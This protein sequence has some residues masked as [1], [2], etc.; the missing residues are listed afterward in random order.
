MKSLKIGI[1]H[2]DINGISYEL[3]LKLF[4]EQEILELCTPVIFGCQ[5]VAD[6]TVKALSLEKLPFYLCENASAAIEGRINLVDVC[7]DEVPA[8]SY[9][10]QTEE[11]LKAEAQSLTAALEAYR[12]RHID[13][14]VTLPGHLS[15]ADGSHSLTNFISRAMGMSEARI[16]DWTINGKIRSLELHAPDASTELGEGLMAESL[17]Q[18][19]QAVHHSMRQDFLLLR[20]RI[21]VVTGVQKLRGILTELHESGITAFGPFE[22]QTF[23]D[24]QWQSHYDACLFLNE[25]DALSHVMDQEEAEN[26]IG[27]VSG[28]PLVL[29]YPM[30]GISYKQ[31][32]KGQACEIPLRQ[33][34]YTAI[35][36]YRTRSSYRHYTKSPLE[37]QWVPR[38]RDDV[39]LDLTKEE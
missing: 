31:A 3:L 27:Y 11:A 37:K 32:G 21:A 7:R 34:I 16:F 1:T 35:D 19:L 14:L 4:Q 25:D 8:I 30:V 26:T 10:Q 22:G 24:G 18:D 39:K 28:L 13:V 5:Q 17:Q 36:I 29:T 23:I 12:D 20:P 2:G 9:G 15:N 6:E 38:G 33:A